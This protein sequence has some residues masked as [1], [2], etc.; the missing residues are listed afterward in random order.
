MYTKQL[1][2]QTVLCVIAESSS[3]PR[4]Y[5][6]PDGEF[7]HVLVIG[8]IVIDRLLDDFCALLAV[9]F[10]PLGVQLL[11]RLFRLFL[12]GAL[13][14]CTKGKKDNKAL[15]GG[16]C[17]KDKTYVHPRPQRRR[18]DGILVETSPLLECGLCNLVVFFRVPGE[19]VG[20]VLDTDTLAKRLDNG[21]RIVEQIV[22]V[23]DANLGLAVLRGVVSVG[24]SICL[25]LSGNLWANLANFTEVVEDTALLVV[26]SLGGHEVVE[27][28][29]L[30]ERRH[31]AAE[32]AGDAVLWVTDE[33]SKVELLQD[34]F[35]NDRGVTRLGLGGV[36]VRSITLARAIGRRGRLPIRANTAL[37]G[38]QR[39]SDRCWLSLRR[40]QIV[41]DILDK[42]ALA[43]AKRGKQ[44]KTNAEL[45]V[46]CSIWLD[47][48]RPVCCPVIALPVVDCRRSPQCNDFE[49]TSNHWGQRGL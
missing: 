43:L 39:R 20:R 28:G 36:G 14:N 5:S 33:E 46:C 21:G 47:G 10:D 37:R 8:D 13:A 31:S 29:D 18:V 6:D 48:T 17:A 41:G 45:S 3:S 34:I 7:L 30:V 9:L 44:V 15:S 4:S 26:A 11:V 16:C 32:V 35:R 2:D 27:A 24:G 25:L 42:D 40:D 1:L 12:F 38:V 23:D 19:E 22:S 49:V